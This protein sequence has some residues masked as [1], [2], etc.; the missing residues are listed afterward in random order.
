[1][2]EENKNRIGI[3]TT[4]PVEIIYAAG[5]IP[6]DLNNIFIT[7][8][9]KHEAIAYAELA[10]FPRA[11]CGWIKGIYGMIAKYKA[12]DK[13]IAV[14][15]GDCSQT[16]ALMETLEDAGIEVIPFS[17]PFD[18]EPAALKMQLD[19]LI[20]RLGTTW[21]KAEDEK[22]RLDRVRNLIKEIDRLGWQEG[23]VNNAEGHYWQV[24][25]SDFE[26]N[27][28]AFYYKADAFIREAKKRD[29]KRAKIRLA[30]IGVP[31]IFDDLFEYLEE[32]GAS[33]VFNEVPR[34]FSMPNNCDGITEQ[35]RKYT[36]PYHVKWRI[37]DIKE[38]CALRNVDGVIHY[39]QS[40][41]FR[42]IED[43]LFRKNLDLPFFSLEGDQPIPL[44]ARTRLRLETFLNI[45]GG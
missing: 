29:M 11:V 28:E 37:E 7:S 20:K 32:R 14:T 12:V 22:L 19:R 40:F 27:P 34:Q 35:Y 38:Q 23:R 42:Q 39:S 3:T 21:E 26:G 9:D 18:R 43:I 31:P 24:S 16:H 6:V 2:S 4:V 17:Y 1:M 30:L 10:G 8:E 45:I 15:E 25:C 13:M 33:V 5:M 36:Y 44:D 41:C